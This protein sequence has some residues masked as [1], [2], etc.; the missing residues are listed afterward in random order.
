[1]LVR[2]VNQAVW[3][4]LAI[5]IAGYVTLRVPGKAA[6][7]PITVGG[8]IAFVITFI[9][10]VGVGRLTAGIASH[11]GGN[12]T[13]WSYYGL[14]LPLIA[15]PHALLKKANKSTPTVAS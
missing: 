10:A 9:V 8:L 3:W 15:L 1:M 6:N 12:Y 13:A 14:C 2:I 4:L 11:K 7:S 5:W